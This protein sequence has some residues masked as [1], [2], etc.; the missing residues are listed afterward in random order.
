[1]TDEQY[2]REKWG[3][4]LRVLPYGSGIDGDGYGLEFD[5]DHPIFVE[6]YE[7]LWSA[8]F[9]EKREEQIRQM[10]EEIGQIEDLLWMTWSEL[11]REMED[12]IETTL[13]ERYKSHDY[14]IVKVR[15]I[16]EYSR[17]LAREQ[18][19]LD[20]LQRGMKGIKHGQ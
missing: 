11:S 18:A 20:D 5:Q 17:I 4:E 16:C 14:L 1:M 7:E 9:T 2:V 19:A 15:D 8:A 6:T 13:S 3:R 12:L 10:G